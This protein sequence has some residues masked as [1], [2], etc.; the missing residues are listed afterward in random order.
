MTVICIALSPKD[1]LA[2]WS[3]IE[4]L[5]DMGYAVGGEIM[6]DDMLERIGDVRMVIWVALDTETAAVLTAVTTELYP[7]RDGLVCWI[8]QCGGTRLWEW[9]H[10]IDKIE[11]YA[12]AEGCVKTILKGRPG[13][14]RALQGYDIRTVTL[15]KAL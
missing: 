8:G 10:F 14:K 7:M 12:R 6:P 15:E 13:W 5:L 11:E 4:P 3:A 9:V 1:A 2:Q